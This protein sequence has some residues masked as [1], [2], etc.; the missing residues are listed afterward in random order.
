MF[1]EVAGHVRVIFREVDIRALRGGVDVHDEG[2]FVR[3]PFIEHLLN[4]ALEPYKD[5]VHRSLV[6]MQHDDI[7]AHDV[8]GPFGD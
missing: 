7:R 2:R 1:H 4:L 5:R 8:D 6:I 3:L